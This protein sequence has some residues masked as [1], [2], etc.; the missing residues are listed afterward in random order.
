MDKPDVHTYETD[1]VYERTRTTPQAQAYYAGCIAYYM[2]R[3]T[4]C[5]PCQES[6]S[7]DEPTSPRDNAIV[8]KS[9]GS[10]I[11]PSESLYQLTGVIEQCLMKVT[12]NCEIHHETLHQAPEEF[13]RKPMIF[14]C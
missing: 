6:L 2:K 3:E 10:L 5:E 4:E 7:N 8:L 9:K 14:H 11:Y 13:P 1:H 12:G